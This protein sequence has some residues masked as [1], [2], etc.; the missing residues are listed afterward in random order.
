MKSFWSEFFRGRK[1]WGSVV[2][3]GSLALAVID[4]VRPDLYF[5]RHFFRL[6]VLFWGAAL[7]YHYIRVY[8]DPPILRWNDWLEKKREERVRKKVAKDPDYQ[9]LCHHCKEYDQK[10]L[11]CTRLR[12][13]KRVKW[14]KIENH[15]Q[16]DYCLYWRVF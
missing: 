15:D 1:Y 2:F 16:K 7:V 6:W 10:R 11:S 8:I 14:L 12:K 13:N 9:T 5:N 3:P 4:F